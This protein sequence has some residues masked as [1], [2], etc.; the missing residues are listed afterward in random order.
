M[1]RYQVFRLYVDGASKG[2]PGEAGIGAILL[3]REGKALFRLGRYIG[4]ATNN[5]AEYRGLILGLEK[6][7]AMG[8]SDLVVLTD[9]E[10]LEKQIK[11]EYRVKDETLKRYHRRVCHLLESF[12]SCRIQLIPREENR[13]ADRLAS[14]AAKR[15]Q[16]SVV[17]SQKPE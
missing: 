7:L 2:N 13:E 3:D 12:R 4:R 16:K 9:S 11:G 1:A 6:A 17:R 15:M 10:L 14:Q 8:R 5:Q